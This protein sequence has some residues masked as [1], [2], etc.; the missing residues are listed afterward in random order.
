MPH[1]YHQQPD[2]CQECEHN[3]GVQLEAAHLENLDAMYRAV[4]HVQ[5][6]LRAGYFD[7]MEVLD[8]TIDSV[9]AEMACSPA[10]DENIGRQA[11][12]D[13]AKVVR[14]LPTSSEST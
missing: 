13:G 5:E 8:A 3:K 12:T 6:V 9:K 14:L 1:R 7:V 11:T 10:R 2:A 4:R